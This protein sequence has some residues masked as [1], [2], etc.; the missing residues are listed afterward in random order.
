MEFVAAAGELRPFVLKSLN[1]NDAKMILEIL[2]DK[3][4]VPYKEGHVPRTFYLTLRLINLFQNAGKIYIPVHLVILLLRIR[5]LNSYR[6]FP[7]LLLRTAKE[8][9]HSTIFT[10]A[11]AMSLPLS[12]SYI[13]S[14]QQTCKLSNLG[15]II[16]FACS[17]A[18]FLEDKK[19]WKDIGLY[20]GSQWTEA[21]LNS[22]KK[23]KKLFWELN[24]WQVSFVIKPGFH[25]AVVRFGDHGFRPLFT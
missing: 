13:Q 15:L 22:L 1:D 16:S 4:V 8:L 20:V 12:Y 5:R 24:K 21:V 3:I 18:I 7:G 2:Q 17:L 19:R 14:I 11:Y 23:Q 6:Y 9:L 10:S 25:Y